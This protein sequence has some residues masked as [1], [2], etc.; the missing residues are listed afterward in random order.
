MQMDVHATIYI[1]STKA[2]CQRLAV[3]S[4]KLHYDCVCVCEIV[5]ADGPM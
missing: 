2:C 1:T 5:D 3:K 4:E